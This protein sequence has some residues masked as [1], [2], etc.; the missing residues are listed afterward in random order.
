MIFV[1]RIAEVTI[2]VGRA[3]ASWFVRQ[4]RALRQGSLV[5]AAKIAALQLWPHD[6]KDG[7]SRW[8]RRS[9]IKTR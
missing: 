5:V 7:A 9:A 1:L 4:R 8:T 2:P 3:K 6:K